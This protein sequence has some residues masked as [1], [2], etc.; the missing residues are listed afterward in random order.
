MKH[1]NAL[2]TTLAAQDWLTNSH[3]PRILHI[4]H[5]VCN[6]INES[7]DVLSVVRPQIGNGPFNLV[8]EDIL[9][10]EHINLHSPVSNSPHQLTLG[11]I[12]IRTANAMLWNPYPDWK[13]LHTRK[14]DIL[15]QL[16]KLLIADDR[17]F[18]LWR[19]VSTIQLFKSLASLLAS[20]DRSPSITAAK[21]L[22]GLGP[23]LTPAGDDFIIGALYAA[24]IIHPGEVASTIAQ[25]IAEAAAPL[26]TSLSAGWLRSAGN[27]EAGALWHE[28]FVALINSD[29]A[30]TRSSINKIL[31][32][33]ATSGADALAGFIGTFISYAERETK[34]CHF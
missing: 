32:V 30:R 29:E 24:W 11:N 25:D 8:T 14:D 3:Q 15:D 21:Q 33:G 19:Q 23:G 1:I 6:L 9:F 20:A 27:G 16:T 12:V 26:T 28:F 13:V 7:R 18:S 4:F 34:L 2:S 22:A 10:S 31:E 5:H 17:E